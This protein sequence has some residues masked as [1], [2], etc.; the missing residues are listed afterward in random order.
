[1]ITCQKQCITTI[2]TMT[3]IINILLYCYDIVTGGR[4]WGGRELYKSLFGG[5]G[6]KSGQEIAAR[7]ETS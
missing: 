3:M 4:R 1:M 5:R 6:K 7:N 2:I